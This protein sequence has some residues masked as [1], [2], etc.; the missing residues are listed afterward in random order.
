MRTQAQLDNASG[1][2]IAADGIHQIHQRVGSFMVV[3]ILVNVVLELRQLFCFHKLRLYAVPPL[4]QILSIILT[5][6]EG[7]R[8]HRSKNIWE[9]MRLVVM[10]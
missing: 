7:G 10:K 5:H 6:G 1:A 4:L 9:I 8:C 3:K 2:A